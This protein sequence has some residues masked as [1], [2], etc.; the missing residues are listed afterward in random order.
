MAHLRF[1]I[2]APVRRGARRWADA[3]PNAAVT[4][5]IGATCG[6]RTQSPQVEQPE[7]NGRPGLLADPTNQAFEPSRRTG[8]SNAPALALDPVKIGMTGLCGAVYRAAR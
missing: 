7:L 5:C 6:A 2:T 1:C 8:G 3:I 4:A